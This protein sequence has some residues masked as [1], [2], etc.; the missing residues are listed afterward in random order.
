[1]NSTNLVLSFNWKAI[2][3]TNGIRETDGEE[4]KD[5]V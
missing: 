1:M 4:Q 5:G 2:D 3:F